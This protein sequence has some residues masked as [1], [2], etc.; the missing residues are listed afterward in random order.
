MTDSIMHAIS[1]ELERHLKP[2]GFTRRGQVYRLPAPSGS[3]AVVQIFK[4]RRSTPEKMLFTVEVGIINGVLAATRYTGVGTG[5]MS[6]ADVLRA[7]WRCRLGHLMPLRTDA[8][9][10][11]ETKSEIP[12]VVEGIAE[13][14]KAHA[15]PVMLPLLDPSALMTL[16]RE[17]RGP[18][19]FITP[20]EQQRFLSILEEELSGA[21]HA[22]NAPGS[23]V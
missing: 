3:V 19:G 22:P 11:V 18:P 23:N 4:S 20:F 9:W 7:H 5:D 16:W 6:K 8:W 13:A 15:L 21:G 17:D 14:L 1:K 12:A 10:S 2:E